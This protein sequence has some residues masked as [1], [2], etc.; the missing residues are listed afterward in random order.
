MEGSVLLCNTRL[1]TDMSRISSYRPD[2]HAKT[3]FER[4]EGQG[5][6]GGE[7]GRGE[8]WLFKRYA[9]KLSR[10]QIEKNSGQK[11]FISLP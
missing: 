6:G 8:S 11:E 3:E 1:I 2:E 9:M 4:E 10:A 5:G 7:G